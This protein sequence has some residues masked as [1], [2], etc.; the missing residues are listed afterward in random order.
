MRGVGDG[1]RRRAEGRGSDGGDCREG[2]ERD[3]R[4]G[5]NRGEGSRGK[6]EIRKVY[7]AE[8]HGTGGTPRGDNRGGDRPGYDRG[9]DRGHDRGYDSRYDRDRERERYDDRERYG[10]DRGGW[11]GDARYG[12]DRGYDRDRERGGYHPYARRRRIAT[13]AVVFSQDYAPGDDP[14]DTQRRWI[15]P[16]PRGEYE[17]GGGGWGH[18]QH[19]RPRDGTPARTGTIVGA[20]STR[21]RRRGTIRDGST[22]SPK[23]T[24]STISNSPRPSSSSRRTARRRISSSSTRTG[25]RTTSSRPRSSRTPRSSIPGTATAARRSSSTAIDRSPKT[26]PA[27]PVLDGRE[28]FRCTFRFTTPLARVSSHED[29][30]ITDRA[31]YSALYEIVVAY[32]L[33]VPVVLDDFVVARVSSKSF[34]RG[35]R[36]ATVSPRLAASLF[37]YPYLLGASPL[38][39]LSRGRAFPRLPRRH[40]RAF[41]L[42]GVWI[43]WPVVIPRDRDPRPRPPTGP[44]SSWSAAEA[45]PA[46]ASRRGV[47]PPPSWDALPAR[48]LPVRGDRPRP[49]PNPPS[50]IRRAARGASTRRRAR[51]R[52]NLVL[53]RPGPRDGDDGGFGLGGF[54]ND[55]PRA[56]AF[57]RASVSSGQCAPGPDRRSRRRRPD[58]P[59]RRPDRA[60][61]RYPANTRTFSSVRPIPGR[62]LGP[63]IP[64]TGFVRGASR[65]VEGTPDGAVPRPR[66]RVPR[67]GFFLLAAAARRLRRAK[68]RRDR[69]RPRRVARRRAHPDGSVT[70]AREGKPA[71]VLFL[72]DDVRSSSGQCS[73]GPGLSAPRLATRPTR[74]GRFATRPARDIDRRGVSPSRRVERRVE[75]AGARGGRRS[76]RGVEHTPGASRVAPLAMFTEVFFA[77]L[78]SSRWYSP[79]PG[80]PRRRR[81]SRNEPRRSRR[82]PPPRSGG[83]P[84]RS[85]PAPGGPFRFR[86]FFVFSPRRAR[87]RRWTCFRNP[88]PGAYSAG[89]GASPRFSRAAAR[90]HGRLV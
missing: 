78:A 77:D 43:F 1:S 23:A 63:K 72:E 6:P 5:G 10:A 70:R 49:S 46:D 11:A 39:R 55:T 74:P 31:L 29:G 50:R 65:G 67:A 28:T 52:Q 60:S 80:T 87:A 44:S 71:R 58:D 88:A 16:T 35:A 48:G 26:R 25:T 66:D 8:N 57:A 45:S 59:T 40:R 64:G 13:G 34:P 38:P 54:P 90:S 62:V 22:S 82:V 37:G 41:I 20:G 17:Y 24:R 15:S 86:R 3:A 81:A 14:R 83:T 27:A 61:Y 30:W 68:I 69:V 9:Y 32:R 42:P 12:A 89:P 76:A 53:A 33:L 85:L 47:T 2:T 7:R 36:R 4:Q 21:A 51:L 56:F 79:A 18:G 19:P 73:P 84:R 75:L